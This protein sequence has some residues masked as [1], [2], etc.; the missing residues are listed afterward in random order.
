MKGLIFICL[1]LISVVF[2]YAQQDFRAKQI[3]D[4]VSQKTRSFKSI[5]ADFVFSMKNEEMDI[6]E[7]NEGSII[8][9]GQ[10]YVVDLPDIGV[11]V[12]S[13]G[14]TI[15]N[16]MEDGNQV[17]ISNME[18]GGSDLMDPSSVFTI[19]EKGFQSK[20]VGEKTTGNQVLHQIELFPDS[21]E[22]GISKILLAIGEP[23]KMIKSAL[24]YDAD[25]NIYGI[26][27]KTMD[28]T[29]DL[30]DSYF[31]FKAGDYVDIE[32]IDFR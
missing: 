12:F 19:Y 29:N 8:L 30:P 2:G 7:R 26:D 28:T 6:N 25:G 13:D 11:K 16:Y 15:W 4:E 5:S 23:D 3:L 18:D 27:V 17:T 14:K 20:Y 9:K 31:V 32:I 22:Y 10:K 1:F 24:L 21:E